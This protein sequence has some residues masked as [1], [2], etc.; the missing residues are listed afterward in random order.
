MTIRFF[1]QPENN[2]TFSPIALVFRE[3]PLIVQSLEGSAYPLFARKGAPFSI[4][5]TTIRNVSP[6]RYSLYARKTFRVTNPSLPSS[7]CNRPHC[8][9]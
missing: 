5:I 3:Y 2:H 8:N 1:R 6:L 9:R 7:P 4:Q